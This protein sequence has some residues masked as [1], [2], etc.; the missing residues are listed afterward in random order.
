M[1][2]YAK[3]EKRGEGRQGGEDEGGE[4]LNLGDGERREE[5]RG[6]FFSLLQKLSGGTISMENGVCPG[7]H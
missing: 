5:G 3:G 7:R 1:R 2:A 6:R 4:L